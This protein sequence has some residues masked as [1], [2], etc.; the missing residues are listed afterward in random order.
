[1]NDSIGDLLRAYVLADATVSGL[2]AS[3]MYPVRL[4]QK[5]TM[6]A[7]VYTQISGLRH[8]HLRGP[9]SAAEPRYQVDAWAL[10]FSEAHQLGKAV[11]RRLEA[12]V[13]EWS[14][15]DSP[16]TS[17]TVAVQFITEY[18]VFEED[19]L[20]GLARHSADYFVF[21]GTHAGSI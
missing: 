4:P 14:G 16:A 13:G 15:N 7:L 12:F 9:A 5:A 20:G 11:R 17:V 2:V 1:V 8:G 10:T 18:D 21:H 3:R 6:P 19:I